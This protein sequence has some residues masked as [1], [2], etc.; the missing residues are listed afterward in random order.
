MLKGSCLCGGVH[1]EAQGPIMWMARCHCTQCRKASGAEFATNGSVKAATFRVTQGED[2]L[3]SF[4]WQSGA[5][6]FFCQRCGSPLF[7]R[8]AKHPDQVRLRLGCLDTDI[9]ERPLVHV[10][11][12]DKQAWS[13]ITDS[14]RQF[15]KAPPTA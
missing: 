13:E 1:Y 14:L 7:K 3:A 9:D 11:V 6:R 5:A 12:S 10:F 2:L 15:D 8:D 4:E